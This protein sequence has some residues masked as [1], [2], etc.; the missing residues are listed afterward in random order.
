MPRNERKAKSAAIA[1]N[2][3]LDSEMD[4]EQRERMEKTGMGI[5]GGVDKGEAKFFEKKMTKEE[6]KAAAEEKRAEIV[7]KKEAKKAEAAAE[8]RRERI[9]RGS[10][11]S[12]ID[13]NAVEREKEAKEAAKE[14]K[15]NKGKKGEE[16]LDESEMLDRLVLN[17][18]ECATH[19][20]AV[21][22]G[23]LGS[24]MDSRDVKLQSVSISLF[25]NMVMEDQNIELTY[26]HRY[27][28]VAQNGSGKSTF[29]K[30]IAS[31]M[32]PIPD[33]IDIWFLDREAE[34]TERTAVQTVIDTVLLEKERL[35]ALE[36]QIMSTVGPADPRLEP[37][38]EKL[39][40]MDPATFQKRA[41]ELL[42]GLGF[43]QAMMH[44]MTK[45]MSGGWRMRVA[46][47]QALFV[48]PMLLVLDEPTN[49]LDLGACV[50]LEDYLSKWESILL[51]TSHSADFLNG[52]CSKIYHLTVGKKLDL[53]GGNYD[54]YVKTRRD[55]DVNNGKRHEK[56]QFDI[57]HL[58]EF[59]SS[60]GT[61][62]NMVKQAQSKQK[63]IDKM[64]EAGLTPKPA[65]DPV[66]RFAF[67][68]CPKIPPPVLAFQDVSFSY[69]GK[70]EDHLYEGLEF[71]IDCDSRIAL[72]GPNGAGKSTLLKLM[73]Q[74]IVPTVG[75]VRR[76]PHL[77]IGRY[78]QH[79]EDVL[80]LSKTPLDFMQ[81]LY[82]DGIVTSEGKVKMEIESW[83]AKLGMFG[84]TGKFQTNLISTLSPGFRARLVFC[85]MSLRNPHLLLL[86]E[87]TNP[88]DMDMI[89]SL[90][91]AIKNFE[92]GMVLVSHDFRLLEQVAE[93]IW[94]CDN[95]AITPWKSDIKAYKD[96][97]R[98]QMAKD[99]KKIVGMGAG[100]G[101]Q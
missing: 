39:D 25:G 81:E 78:N 3:E 96:H 24:R 64:V 22:T 65:A 41:G 83:R 56:E 5:G 93:N 87:P 4:D 97:L 15:K 90:A 37:I 59:I 91:L 21:A 16:K 45:D 98:K 38:Y 75:D 85:L 77:R 52:V 42:F 6:K 47:A 94:V 9:E 20:L 23:V 72:V 1:L 67:P 57:K 86:D 80:D 2:R 79:S 100:A 88:L 61:Y 101:V 17:E 49:H 14:A 73:E 54:S 69:S 33:F 30:V 36:E 68:S 43:S 35:E 32:I 66:F 13:E 31:R 60:C 70:K 19:K 10:N 62:S 55:Q 82:P 84:V 95:K 11:V 40:K 53:Y 7:A 51:L 34:P 99:V 46:L 63:I 58:K 92:G 89:D 26:G 48:K 50:W 18:T 12:D 27:G 29:L 74:D 8:V 71:G 76:N 44:R 28:L